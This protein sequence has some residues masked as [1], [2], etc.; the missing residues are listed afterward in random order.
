MTDDKLAKI[1]FDDWNWGEPPAAV[2]LWRQASISGSKITIEALLEEKPFCIVSKSGEIEVL[3]G[4]FV[5]KFPK[6]EPSGGGG[7]DGHGTSEISE[8]GWF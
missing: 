3:F 4:P 6:L 5:L 1:D 2:D 7:T 8:D